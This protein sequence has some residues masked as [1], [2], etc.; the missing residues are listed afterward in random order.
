M[1]A[2]SNTINH[3]RQSAFSPAFLAKHYRLP[4]ETV[5]AIRAGRIHP[6]PRLLDTPDLKPQRL[7]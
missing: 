4:V 5:K 1:I 6:A 2:S 7:R 3:I